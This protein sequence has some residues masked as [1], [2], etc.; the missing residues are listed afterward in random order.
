MHKCKDVVVAV[1]KFLAIIAFSVMLI[2]A[3]V[4][5]I[6]RYVFHNSPMWT[7]ELARYMF[8]TASMCAA[9]VA[10]DRKGHMAV[11]ILT[12]N[13]EGGKKKF[14]DCFAAICGII[15]CVLVT[16]YGIELAMKTYSQPSPAMHIP[17]GLVYATIPAGCIGM[18][19]V[20]VV[21]L[22]DSIKGEES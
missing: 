22:I 10:L 20:S 2:S 3:G 19:I 21:Q 18:L 11:D 7:E 6:A 16:K 15:F 9:V 4:Q 17:I 1:F 5:V 13:A 14:F 8:I 12:A